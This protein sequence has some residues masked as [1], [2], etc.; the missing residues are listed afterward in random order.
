MQSEFR[1]GNVKHVEGYVNTSHLFYVGLGVCQ[2]RL[3]LT[4]SQTG[5]LNTYYEG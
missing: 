4:L 3:K 1:N 5:M 2:S